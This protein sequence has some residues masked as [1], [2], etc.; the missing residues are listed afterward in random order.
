MSHSAQHWIFNI[1]DGEHFE[2]SSSQRIW[3]IKTQCTNGRAYGPGTSFVKNAKD[4]DTLW[5]IK[6]RTKGRIYSVATFIA[7]KKRELGPLITLTYSSIE[8]GW[9]NNGD[10]W[11]TE[12]HYKE[13]YN[14][15]KCNIYIESRLWSCPYFRTEPNDEYGID[16]NDEYRKIVRYSMAVRKRPTVAPFNPFMAFSGETLSED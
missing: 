10:S 6:S 5:F 4:G 16:W 8:L 2:N 15:E 9:S 7:T 11:D 3:G 14:V 1:G 12:V 13:L